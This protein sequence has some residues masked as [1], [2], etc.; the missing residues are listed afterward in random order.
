MENNMKRSTILFGSIFSILL[1]V[2]IPN[3]N[4][5]EYLTTIENTQD[6]NENELKEAIINRINKL[7]EE[8]T[9]HKIRLVTED[10][11]GP[12]EG[13]L[14]DPYDWVYLFTGTISIFFLGFFIKN[15]FIKNALLS[16][17]I[18]GFIQWTINYGLYTYNT[19]IGFGEA[20]DII[21]HYEDGY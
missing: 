19:L 8:N 12:F 16:G 1:L 4:A 17:D 20:F 15:Q 5:V 14:D 11:D 18:R 13:G 7:E 21:E 2:L 10:P 3:I 6:F 9:N